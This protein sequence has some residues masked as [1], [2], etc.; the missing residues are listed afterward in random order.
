MIKTN[1]SKII[2]YVI[3]ILLI[4]SGTA[5]FTIFAFPLRLRIINAGNLFGFG[6]AVLMII[7]GVFLP[8]ITVIVKKIYSNKKGKK[9]LI[10]LL[11]LAIAGMALFFGTLGSIISAGITDA[12]T[13]QTVIVLGCKVRGT[14]P[15]VLLLQRTKAAAEY[16]K[17]SPTASA[18]LSGGQGN[19][20]QISEAQCMYNIMM[21]EGIDPSRLYI[22]DKSTSTG[23]NIAFSKKIIE[24]NNLS[25]DVA[26]STSNFH[27]KRARIICK[28]NGLNASSISSPTSKYYEPTY[29]VREVFGVWVQWIKSI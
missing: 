4:I 8:K 13:Q 19:D 5:I 22:E 24:N 16:L 21:D 2:Q 15:G 14:K 6:V 1:K 29:Y 23:E 9:L 28:E 17:E 18:I 12:D 26:V 20:E 7:S 3:R 10:T 11:C 25:K 27:Q